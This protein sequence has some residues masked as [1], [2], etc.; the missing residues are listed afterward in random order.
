MTYYPKSKILENQFTSGKEF[1]LKSNNQPYTGYYY[2][3]SNNTFFTGKT[4]NDPNTLELVLIKPN[5]VNPSNLKSTN[6]TSLP[7]PF[8]PHPTDID[9]KL[10]FITRYFLKRR[11]SD[12]TT[13]REISFDD[14][15]VYLNGVDD[16]TNL[17]IVIKLNWRLGIN[18]NDIINTN[19][20]L[21]QLKE[22][23]FPNFSLWF[24]DFAQFS[25]PF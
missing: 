13:I 3:L 12:Y 22:I 7:S 23:I 5:I 14:Y 25:G 15:Q 11:N 4:S 20:K 6:I 2:A 10:G 17:Y 16:N 21:V 24:R 19:K 1:A 8:Y 9:R 18:Q